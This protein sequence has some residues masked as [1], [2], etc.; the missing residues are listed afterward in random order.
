MKLT[1]LEIEETSPGI[2]TIDCTNIQHPSERTELGRET[3][4][5]LSA[6]NHSHDYTIFTEFHEVG[7]DVNEFQIRFLY[8]KD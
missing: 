3:G 1:D 2:D 7:K 4:S 6:N 8:P 5:F